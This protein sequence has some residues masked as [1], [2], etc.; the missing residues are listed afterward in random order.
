MK[1]IPIQAGICRE[2]KEPFR[3]GENIYIHGTAWQTATGPLV[4][5]PYG[6][7][8]APCLVTVMKREEKP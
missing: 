4:L 3:A 7:Y 5:E 2:C 8:H 6:H 1:R